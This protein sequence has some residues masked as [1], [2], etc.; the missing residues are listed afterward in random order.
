MNFPKLK[1]N[2]EIVRV[3][4]EQCLDT[5]NK[6]SQ[7]IYVEIRDKK[8]GNSMCYSLIPTVSEIAKAIKE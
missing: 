2:L 6:N 8:T 3:F 7:D 4:V 5:D 1:H